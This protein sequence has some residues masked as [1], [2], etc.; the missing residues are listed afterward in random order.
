[1][2]RQ[3]S[4]RD[5]LKYTGMGSAAA[6]ASAYGM[7]LG[8]ALAQAPPGD[9]AGH[10]VIYNFGGA[11]Q[12]QMIANAI[13]RFNER[14]PNVLVEDLYIPW[15]EGWGHYT[16]NLKLRVASGLKTDIIAIAIEGTR[17]TIFEDL[18][19]PM[20]DAIAADEELAA[21]VDEVEPVLHDALKGPDGQTYYFTREWNNMIIHYNTAIFEEAGLDP[22]AVD[23]TWEDF[24]ETSLVLTHGEGADKKFGFAIPYF[25]FGLTPWWHTNDTSTLTPDWS[26]SNLDDPK[27]LESVKFV[28][29]LVHEHGVAPAVEGLTMT[30]HFMAGTAAMT[31]A[32]RWPFDTYVSTDWR[33]V[34]ITPWPRNRAGTTVFGSGGWAVSKTAENVPLALELIKN[35]TAIET[36]ME[37]VA[38]GTSLPAR[39]SAT[40]NELFNSFPA[41]AQRFFGSLEDIK[42]VPSPENFSEYE[43]IFMRHMSQIMANSVTPEQGLEA[44]HIELTAAMDKLAERMAGG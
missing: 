34:D 37:A 26:Q 17:E 42:P 1:M 39:R 30:E 21:I 6:F 15:P 22:P 9:T 40:E 18:V 35:L 31:G 33:T 4:R 23:W 32:G 36:D 27:M 7:P 13:G 3:V 38:V 14:Y 25:N 24:L 12:Q 20:D 10:L 28:H 2:S 5:F 19:L 8:T 11:E 29:S 44:A 41:N 43:A 16:T